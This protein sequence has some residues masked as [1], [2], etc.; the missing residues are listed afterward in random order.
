MMEDLS[1][2]AQKTRA[3]EGRQS[4]SMTAHAPLT[5]VLLRLSL[6][7]LTRSLIL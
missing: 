2:P 3:R 6:S 7:G 5:L 4:R 1:K